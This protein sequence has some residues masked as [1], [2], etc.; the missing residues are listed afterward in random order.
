MSTTIPK[1][2]T[3]GLRAWFGKTEAIKGISFLLDVLASLAPTHPFQLTVL[4]T[5]TLEAELRERY[6][7]CAWV[8]FGG[9]VPRAD[10]AVAMAQSDV[11]CMPSLWSE[12]Y[13]IVTAQ[14]LQIGTPVIGSSNGG[15]A[16]LIR[17]EETGLLVA[18]GDATAWRAAFRRM[19]GAPGLLRAWRRNA[20]RYSEEFAA[21]RIGEA[22]EAFVSRL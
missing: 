5:G 13:G 1:L 22:Y 8:T 16:E 11:L 15:T 18:P 20:L 17:H 9:F 14:A 2:Q 3:H 10:V 21:E 12:T 6:G 4:G 7:K 19:I